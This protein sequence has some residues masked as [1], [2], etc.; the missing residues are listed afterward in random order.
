MIG[1]LI[2]CQHYEISYP[3]DIS[4]KAMSIN[5][6]F[7]FPVR[8]H[9]KLEIKLD[10]INIKCLNLKLLNLKDEIYSEDNKI[11]KVGCKCFTCSNNYTKAYIHHLL[12][13]NEINATILLIMYNSFKKR[14]NLYFVQELIKSFEEHLN[15][16]LYFYNFLTTQCE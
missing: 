16:S 8:I 11:L 12:K 7:E 5:S 10:E 15:K 2:G 1:I 14:H 9:D 13:C 3:F 6:D 4:E